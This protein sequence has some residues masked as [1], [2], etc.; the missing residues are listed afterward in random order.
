MSRH[1]HIIN[2]L[3]AFF[4]HCSENSTS[5]LLVNKHFKTITTEDSSWP[6][7]IFDVQL[8]NNSIPEIT[9]TISNR[10]QLNHIILDE[11]QLEENE[12]LL[13]QYGFIPL[14]EWACL[15]FDNSTTLKQNH[16]NL[17]I[18][19]TSPKDLK[20]WIGVASSGFKALSLEL[21]KNLLSS[22]NTTL[23]SGYHQNKLIATALLFKHNN[24]AGIYHVVTHP[25]YRNKGFG[26]EIFSFC[27]QE[28]LKNKADRV[29]AQSTQEGLNTWI[30]TGMKQYGN[31]YL[32]CWNK[33]KQ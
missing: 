29:I 5:K 1:Q 32:L 12:D 19:T 13:T 28:A 24:T 30:D 15:E 4:E 33:P 16:N 6:N 27:E 3:F 18:K 26:A 22:K 2:H 10:P 14:A 17:T 31:F 25:N 20:D 9:E 21:F 7:F 8:N 11:K 23:Y